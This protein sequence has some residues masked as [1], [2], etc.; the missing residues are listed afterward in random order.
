MMLMTKITTIR[1]E[2]YHRPISLPSLTPFSHRH[3]HHAV[4][5]KDLDKNI[6]NQNYQNT[7]RSFQYPAVSTICRFGGVITRNIV[8]LLVKF[9]GAGTHQVNRNPDDTTLVLLAAVRVGVVEGDVFRG[10]HGTL[11]LLTSIVG[12]WKGVG[13][14]H[15]AVEAKTPPPPPPKSSSLQDTYQWSGSAALV[16]LSKAIKPECSMRVD[17]LLHL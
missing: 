6:Q 16:G 1:W 14:C 7:W 2:H 17:L 15:E 12:I 8:P 3:R 13:Q 11:I 5:G 10:G 9:R 4:K